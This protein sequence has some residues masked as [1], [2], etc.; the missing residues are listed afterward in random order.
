MN[1]KNVVIVALVALAVYFVVQ[2]SKNWSS[3]QLLR[4]SP[5]RELFELGV[6]N[7]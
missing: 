1:T 2:R 5:Q 7:S 4:V 6:K 3:N